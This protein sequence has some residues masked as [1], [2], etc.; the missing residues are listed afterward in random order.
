MSPRTH[1]KHPLLVAA[2]ALGALFVAPA[3]ASA[4]DHGSR[5]VI[6]AQGAGEVLVRPNS[7]HV[8]VG[9]ETQA[10]SLD[11]AMSQVSARIERVLDAIKA[12]DLPELNIET[13]TVRFTPVYAPPREG[14]PPSISGYSA[15]NHVLITDKGVG[16]D[17]LAARAAKIVDT[18]L[19]AGANSLGGVDFFVADPS[20][21]EDQALALAVQDAQHD[22]DTIAKAAGATVTGMISVEEASAARVP[23]ALPLDVTASFAAS[24][25]TPIEVGEISFTSEVTAKFTFQR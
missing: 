7:V 8:D 14:R 6:V 13:R 4:S 25:S 22:A 19:G 21:A 11:E 9:A 18:A 23:R 5:S 16:A 24:V 17:G 1:L 2:L 20:Q 12:L 15:S 10:G 3:H